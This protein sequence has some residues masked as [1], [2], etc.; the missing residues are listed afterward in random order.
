M[1]RLAARVALSLK[2]AI[3]KAQWRR[4][5][6]C[7]LVESGERNREAEAHGMEMLVK[8]EDPTGNMLYGVVQ[9]TLCLSKPLDELVFGA[10][11]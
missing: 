9:R 1:G 4:N 7:V 10:Q 6:L 5:A 11:A 3:A 8:L 2:K